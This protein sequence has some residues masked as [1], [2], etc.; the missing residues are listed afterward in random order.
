MGIHGLSGYIRKNTDAYVETHLSNFYG[1]KIAVDISVFLYKSVRTQ[2]D[3]NWVM[4]IVLLLKCLKKYG[5]KIVCVFDGPNVPPEKLKERASRKKSSDSVQRKVNEVQDCI[6]LVNKYIDSKIEPPLELRARIRDICKKQRDADKFDAI[7]YR[8]VDECIRV[9]TMTE[10]KFAKQCI[11]ITT[12]HAN[13]VKEIVKHLGMA[14]MQADGEAETMCAYMCIKGMVDGVLTEDTDVLAYGTPIFLCKF[15]CKNETV[16]VIE[17]NNLINQLE[18]NSLQFKDFCIMCACDYNDRIKL[19]QKNPEK[20]QTGIGPA[21][22]YKLL[23]E[24]GS[25]DNIEYMTEL[26]VSPLI[27][28]RCRI[29][30]TASST[31]TYDGLVLPYNKPIDLPNVERFMKKNRCSF[32]LKQIQEIWAP[33][34]LEFISDDEIEAE[35][36]IELEEISDDELED[37]NNNNNI[38]DDDEGSELQAEMLQEHAKNE[39]LLDEANNQYAI[40]TDGSCLGNPGPGGWG[41]IVLYNGKKD[42]IKGGSKHTTNNKMEL[43]AAI[44]GLRYIEDDIIEDD[45]IEDD[46]EIIVYTDSTYVKK[47]ITTWIKKWKS[48]GWKTSDNKDVKNKDLWKSLDS[49]NTKLNVEWRWVKAHNGDKYNEEV[50]K[51]AR[52]EAYK[53]S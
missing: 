51:I 25:I 27:Y 1:K 13:I 3:E 28:E 32:L 35:S 48:E 22:A 30:F 23:Q 40:Y 16:M 24:H 9:L 2:G 8:N 45:C 11:P 6:K 36:E 12:D 52:S 47:G 17:Y 31:S 49:L 15:D 19:P 44:E 5:I 14:V 42:I 4:S 38:S 20:R 46:V 21:K 18:L 53:F 43:T 37:N 26:D 39:M 50:D 33:T 29:L 7:D 41:A 10:K 34:P